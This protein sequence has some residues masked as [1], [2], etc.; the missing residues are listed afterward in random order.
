MNP[1]NQV[2]SLSYKW[3]VVVHIGNPSIPVGKEK[4]G[5]EN[6]SQTIT[7]KGQV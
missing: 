5:Q 4:W 2:L 1:D 6:H 7:A 3:N